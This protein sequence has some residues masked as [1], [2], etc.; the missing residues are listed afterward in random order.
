MLRYM[1]Y[2]NLSEYFIKYSRELIKNILLKPPHY[3]N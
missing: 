3:I 2:L 1:K